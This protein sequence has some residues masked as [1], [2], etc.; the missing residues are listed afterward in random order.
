MTNNI[1][2]SFNLHRSYIMCTFFLNA[3]SY[4]DEFVFLQNKQTCHIVCVQFYHSVLTRMSLP[5]SCSVQSP[6]VSVIISLLT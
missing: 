4:V 2:P 5:I 1:R 3:A 6:N